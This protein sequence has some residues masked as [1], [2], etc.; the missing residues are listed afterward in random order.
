MEGKLRNKEVVYGVTVLDGEGTLL[1][2]CKKLYPEYIS[3][4]SIPKIVMNEVLK[5]A[6]D[7]GIE[8]EYDAFNISI[9]YD[10]RGNPYYAI[11]NIYQGGIEEEC[12]EL[13]IAVGYLI[14]EPN[15]EIGEEVD[16]KSN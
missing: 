6:K 3:F 2:E 8:S 11:V 5:L 12:L 16:E 7:S 9:M 14:E 13:T 1:R 15:E 10:E 4:E